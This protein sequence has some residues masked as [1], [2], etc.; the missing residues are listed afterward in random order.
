MLNESWPES[1]ASTVSRLTQ[2]E[3]SGWSAGHFGPELNVPQ[4]FMH[5]SPS[6]FPSFLAYRTEIK[7]M[8]CAQDPW[9][10]ENPSASRCDEKPT[11]EHTGTQKPLSRLAA[12]SSKFRTRATLVA[13]FLLASLAREI[14]T[15]P[16]PH[17]RLPHSFARAGL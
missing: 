8:Q 6:R 10:G 13:V 15:C 3:P 12:A 7:H 17:S 1:I 9:R 16:P 5:S 2:N 4:L 14:P 11:P